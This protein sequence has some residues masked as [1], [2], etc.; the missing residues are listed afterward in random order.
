MLD[1]LKAILWDNRNEPFLVVMGASLVVILLWS[2]GLQM[3]RGA[4]LV[5]GSTILP[6]SSANCPVRP[7]LE[8]FPVGAIVAFFGPDNRIP[9]GWALLNGQLAPENSQLGFDADS[10]VVG[11]QL[12]DLRGRFIRGSADPL[13]PNHLAMGGNDN[14]D[15]SHA[16][17]WARFDSDEDWHSYKNR[18]GNLTNVDNWNNGIDD[19]GRGVYPLLVEEGTSLYTER[20][21]NAEESNLPSYVELRWIIRVF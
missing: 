12:P 18:N 8:P 20:L 6:A 17:R 1:Q 11:E 14:T 2:V 9:T 7:E 16:H 13:Q 19:D 21:G 3:R 4:P 10:A 15:W 5:C